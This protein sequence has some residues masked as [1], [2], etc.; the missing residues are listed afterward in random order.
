MK[1]STNG[2]HIAQKPAKLTVTHRGKSYTL[3][4]IGQKYQMRL[5]IE[6]QQ[7]SF[8]VEGAEEAIKLLDRL[9]GPKVGSLSW[10]YVDVFLPTQ[11]HA[12]ES[13]LGNFAKA[14]D[15][16]FLPAFGDLD[17]VAIKRP[18][19]QQYVNKLS[20]RLEG[21][22]LRMYLNKFGEVLNLARADEY[23]TASPI[24]NVRVAKSRSITTRRTLTFREIGDLI[25][26]PAPFGNLYICLFCLGM[27]YSEAAALKVS[28]LRDHS[29]HLHGL[30]TPSEGPKEEMKNQYRVRVI[31]LP[32]EIENRLRSGAGNIFLVEPP[33]GPITSKALYERVRDDLADLE[34]VSSHT[35]RRSFV[36]NMENILECPRPICQ[37][38]IGHAGENMTD[39]YNHGA[40]ERSRKWL[41]RYWKKCLLKRSLE[42][43]AKNG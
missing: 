31:P 43:E 19:I 7:K 1:Q 16:Y 26:R 36:S 20:S 41:A 15:G 35:G 38:I 34:D 6:G 23:I 33:E 17:L 21:S 32:I 39:R 28:D 24:Q 12:A 29:L 25:D 8:Y 2:K 11:I 14:M 10:F 13:T 30:N 42:I 37:A 9:F 27:S 18:M 22:T 5:R 40:I 3:R 4:L